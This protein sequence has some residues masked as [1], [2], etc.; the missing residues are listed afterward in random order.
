[1]TVNAGAT[2]A[3]TGNDT[4]ATLALA[5]TL[6]GSGTLTAANYALNGGTANAN[7]GAGALAS[8]G[9]STIAGTAAAATVAVNTGTLT[10]A[11]A[12]R[13]TAPAAVNVA[14][15]ATLAMVGDQTLGSLAGTGSVG[16]ASFTLSTGAAGNS[17]FGGVIQ[18]SGNL[19][20]QGGSTFTL[21]GANSYT[22]TTDV[23]AGVLQIGDDATHGSVASSGFSVAGTLRSARSDDASLAAPISGTGGV[24]Q[25]GTGRLTLSGGNKTYSGTTA[26]TRG[27]LLTAGSED[28]PNGSAVTVA[29]GGRLTLGGV[30]TLKSIDADGAVALS[31]N[32]I[33]T[34][35][36]LL[37]GPVTVPGGGAVALSGRRIDAVSDGNRWGSSLA[38]DARDNVKLSSGR[39]NGELRNLV[40]G[41]TTVAKGGRIDAGVLTLNAVT[42][43]NGGTLELVASAPALP[44]APGTDVVNRQA[45][46]LPISLASD[47][48]LQGSGASISVAN[49][50]G[51]RVQALRG[52]SVRLDELGNQFLGAL[53]VLSGA[54]YGTAWSSNPV[55]AS[56]NGGP[57]IN[58]ALQGRVRVTGTTINVGGSGI[59]ADVAYIT[60]DRLTTLGT[61]SRIVSRLPYDNT[62]GT[63]GSLPGLTLELTDASF[64]QA[65]PYGQTGGGEIRIDVGSRSLGNRVV[66]PD[67]GYVT[68]LPRGG[69]KGT[70]A[71]LLAGPQTSSGGY[72]FFFDG[73][74]VQTEVPVYY[75]GV[76]PVTPAML[77]SISA[78]VAVSESARKE[79]FDEAIRT[80]NV[81]VRLRSGVIA[82]VGPGRPATQGAEGIRVPLI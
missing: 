65:A 13:L 27:E 49:G 74:G 45:A 37:R 55:S 10:L 21:S 11:S 2:L 26:V 78:T 5:G 52:G 67:A 33:A 64:L 36:L 76:L 47:A 63:A 66:P 24:E 39:A 56:F 79:R 7:L 3:L 31:G 44:T 75:N 71:V 28:L 53:E 9:A 34:E 6:G 48:V 17:N 57:A 46:G 20:K 12:N 14:T 69:A 42:T 50:A 23:Q 62:V 77:N 8:T 68:V 19:V 25:A 38:L 29:A 15:G 73:A 81:A 35:D 61:S 22:G 58:Y 40:L 72:R 70:T 41:T 60:A 80:E 32:L 4:V 30:E 51:L 18:G 1:M 54:A 82:E 59:E 43:V 16:L